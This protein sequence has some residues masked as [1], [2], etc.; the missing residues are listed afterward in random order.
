M[1][2]K[3]FTFIKNALLNSLVAAALLAGG[4]SKTEKA[5]VVLPTA[6]TYPV[7]AYLTSTS[8]QTGGY[9][10]S[11]G[12]S[13]TLTA[14]GVVYSATNQAPTITDSKTTDGTALVYKSTITGLTAGTTYYARAYIQNEAGVGYGNVIKFTTSTASADT[15]VTVSTFAG[16]STG[17]FGNG[18]GTAALFNSPQGTAVDGAGNVYVSDSFN[19]IIRKITPAGVVTTYAGTAGVLGFAGGA[20]TV[21]KFYSPQGIAFDGAGNLYVADQ[22]NNAIYKITSTGTVTVLA[23]D[24][25]AGYADGVGSAARFYS[26]QGIAADAQGNVYVA[27]RNN[28]RIRKI[29]PAG[30]V[31][32]FAGTGT[33]GAYVGDAA[34]VAQFNRPVAVAVDAAGNNVYVADQGNYAIRKITAGNVTTLIGNTYYRGLVNLV[35]GIAIDAANNLY[36]TDQSGRVLKI[37]N[38]NVL[39]TLGG[40]LET[41][42][43]LDG[44]KANALFSS[45]VGIA[46]SGT[47]TLYVA[48]YNNNRIRKLVIQ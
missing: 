45:P 21:G 12:S 3:K 40:K 2:L 18:T 25:T 5:E 29:T 31:T 26:P 28:D 7:V 20:A 37:S 41:S 47:N 32:T 10:S 34:T 23:G 24:G 8:V 16:N 22:G 11:I 39:Y 14:A 30:V 17:G 35:A 15:T 9:V 48:D 4:C 19:H 44:T 13:A 6:E 27:D 1:I 36:I 43:F 46:V 33:A 42:G 38:Q